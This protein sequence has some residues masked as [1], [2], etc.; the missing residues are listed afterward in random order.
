MSTRWL[1]PAF[2][3]L[4]LV[5]V[6][7]PLGAQ[8]DEE[9]TDSSAAI[10]AAVSSL[11]MRE[12][13][14]AVMGGRIA[15]IEVS[16]ADSSTWYVAVGS[17]G[18]WKT[19]N[20]GITW[21]PIFDDQPSYSI[22]EV[23]ID[24]T[25]AD[26]IWV[27]T[28]ENVS[29]RH[30]AWGTGVYK[31]MDGGRSWKAMGLTES[32]HIGRILVDPRDSEVVFVAA[33]GPLWSPGGDRGLFRSWD[34]GAT[35]DLVLEVDEN[36]GITD[37][38]FDPSEPDTLYAAAYQRRRHVWSFLGG[39]P[40]SGIYKSTD[41]GN[42]WREITNG[43]PSGDIGKIGLAV[44]PA[45]PDRVYATVEADEDERG[46]YRSTD[47]GE[48]WSKRN[49]YI[50][51][52]TGPHY[53]QE[54]EAS[55]IDA[56]VVYQMDVF[57]RSTRD[58]GET[59]NILG[60]GSEKHS[61][62]HALWIDPANG[63]H[64][65]AG[66]D[67]GLYE[68][69]DNGTTWRH[70]R[71]LPI[72]QFYKVAVDNSEPFYNI[73]GGA[74]DLGTLFGPARTMNTE[75]IRNRDW[76]VPL[77]ADGYAVDFDPTDPDTMY[78]EIQQGELVRVDKRNNETVDIK[79]QA[80]PGDP[81]DRW[82]WDAPLLISP[83][84][85][86]RLYFG[87]QRV[88][89][90]DDR[91]DSWTSV[92]GDL[93][94]NTIRYTL[95]FM[96]RVWS[97]DSLYDTGAMSKYATLTTITESPITEG[98]LYTGSDDG[99]V[100]ATL[101][102]G[103]T[104]TAAA[105]LPGVPERSFI[106]DM[107][108]SRHDAT[109]VF[110]V[111]DAHK[112]G[113]YRPL[114]FRSDDNG[115]SWRSIAGDLPEDTILWAI[116]Q[117]HENPD[118]LFL[119]AEYG[120]YVTVDGG[121]HWN[122]LGGTPTIAFRDIKIHRRDNDLVGA[123]F[124]RGFYVLDD[125]T[126]LRT[127]ADGI[128]GSGAF[129]VRNAWWY[130]PSEPM[131]ASGMPSQG[132]TEYAGPNPPFGALFTYHVSEV[133]ATA[134]EARRKRD[135]EARE[136]GEDAEFPGWDLLREEQAE[137]KPRVML[138]VSDADGHPVRWVEG[139]AS[140]GLHRAAWDLRG[141]PIDPISLSSGGFRPPW[142]S[143]PQGPMVAPGTYSVQLKLLTSAG[144]TSLGEPQP[145]EVV[146]VPNI[147]GDADV[148]ASI[149]FQRQVADLMREVGGAGSAIGEASEKLTYMRAALV[150]TPGA[151]E[152]LF[153]RIDEVEGLLQQLQMRLWGDRIRS[154]LNEST[155]PSIAN[156]IGRVFGNVI[157]TREAP[158]QTQRDSFGIGARDFRAFQGDLKSLLDGTFA[159]LEQ[160]LEAAGAPWTPGRRIR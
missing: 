33:E 154:Q 46:F 131:Q 23:T 119:G 112:F 101:D 137:T 85:P 39:G 17:G 26:V 117:D 18:L 1:R 35:W 77:G 58:G 145:F 11:R 42:T 105:T 84:D 21:T 25:N 111:A 146:P 102:G 86:S 48:S 70:S 80:A 71:N 114:V 100:H 30:V 135:L 52:G 8:T 19:T 51:G 126:P 104:W 78:M 140:I 2:V 61:D 16:H 63:N 93:T 124:G 108:A 22:G 4:L 14:P 68:S 155:E 45:D 5:A 7:A 148:R 31:S 9:P 65:I 75:G 116:Q 115:A 74:Q 160:A 142:A 50:S 41:G 43:L 133:P 94:T 6:A 130:V 103:A 110:V 10:S 90:S 62:N 79:P 151:D 72:S 99:L 156:R 66:T 13:G 49:S 147:A 144:M 54:I 24:P 136:R 57:I 150:Q 81:A 69:F 55:P 29:G 44:T 152:A 67:G 118:L 36:T 73:L 40:E 91:G 27:G 89:R 138:L 88:W 132:S 82:N 139:A 38:E 96:D 98:V 53:Y 127:I 158:T 143:D 3:L 60:N 64:L 157:G 20:A 34:G 28:G 121:A 59:F 15:D 37:V 128:A 123:T 125:Y 76:Y 109:G 92:S 107:E 149:A 120:V 47:K 97:I 83:H 141:A 122:M 32:E 87:S 12:I 134:A 95:E 56:D 113:D 129:P 159:E 106:N 153:T